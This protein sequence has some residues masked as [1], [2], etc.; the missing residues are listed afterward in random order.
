MRDDDR[1]EKQRGIGGRCGSQHGQEMPRDQRV[2]EAEANRRG[3]QHA[4]QQAR[5]AEALPTEAPPVPSQRERDKEDGEEC[6]D[7]VQATLR[8]PAS[9]AAPRAPHPQAPMRHRTRPPLLDPTGAP[10]DRS[11][12]ARRSARGACG[13]ENLHASS[14]SEGALARGHGLPLP[15]HARLLV[16]LALP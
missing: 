5:Q 4:T 12:W 11:G 16:V 1:P 8:V 9:P 15:T 7:L 10:G 14:A 13:P 6:V 3:E 2:G